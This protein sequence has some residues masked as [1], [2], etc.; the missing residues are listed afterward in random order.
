M[1]KQYLYDIEARQRIAAGVRKLADAVRVTLGPAG[2]N[3]I[4]EK[5]FGSPVVTKDGVTVAKEVELEDPFENM[6]AKL[7]T[8][9][10]QKTNDIAGDGTTSATVLADAILRE[11]LK[12]VAA[13]AEPI[14]LKRGID[15]AVQVVV[16]H[17]AK[18]SKKVTTREQKAAVATISANHDREIGDLLAEAVERVGKDGVITVE[19][20]K[21]T[22]TVLDFV[23]GMQFDKGFL[24]PYFITDTKDLSCVLEDPYILLYE[25]KLSSLR[26][27]IPVLEAVAHSGRPLL[28]VAEDVEGECLAALVVNRLRGALKVC[29]VKAPGFGERRKAM[30]QDMAVLTG[31]TFISE[32]LGIKLDTVT[33]DQLGTCKK[34]IVNK[35]S[36]TLSEGAGTKKAIQA[37][38]SQIRN[39]IESSTS[40]YDTEKLQERLAKLQGGVAVVKVGA[41]TE[42]ALKEK[43]YRVED[44]LNATRAAV[45][46]GIVP[47]GGTSLIRALPALEDL[48]VR[49]QDER[50]GVAIIR[51]ALEAPL[52]QLAANTGE[53]GAVVVDEVQRAGGAK[54]WDARAQ[55]IVDMIKE[56]IIDPAKV[57]R[58]GLQHAAS[59]AA[60]ILTTETLITDLKDVDAPADG[61]QT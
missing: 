38:I 18:I 37:R 60:M 41:P 4:A 54:G 3:V 32:D 44:A 19:E 40:D 13:G 51:R 57:V 34:V 10:A 1:A 27:L 52:R 30:L 36:T 7:V 2:R 12:A 21:S 48:R 58:S 6:G 29:A 46:E 53:E 55:K 61:A 20:G 17:V 31:G 16:E 14:A 11:G 50:M 24:S 22:E 56:G 28:V 23:D 45:E 9:A 25:K 59:I 5:S 33:V 35:D 49:G 39:Q 42:A 43:K 47:G 8:E 15:K 26:E